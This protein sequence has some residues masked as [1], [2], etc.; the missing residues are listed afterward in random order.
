VSPFCGN[1]TD[2]GS[3]HTFAEADGSDTYAHN[4]EIAFGGVDAKFVRIA[5]ISNYGGSHAGLSE[6]RFYHS[7]P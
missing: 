7:G 3:G 2:L 4:T 6:V 1:W 5:A